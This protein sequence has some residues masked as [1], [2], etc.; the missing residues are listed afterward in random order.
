[1]KKLRHAV[2]YGG[3]RLALAACDRLDPR[4]AFFVADRLADAWFLI[5]RRRRRTAVSN[6][7]A[8]GV[9]TDPRRAFALARA[10]FRHMG[11][12]IVESLKAGDVL[13]DEAGR[14][15]AVEMQIHPGAMEALAAPGRGVIVI[16]GHIGNW[17]IAARMLSFI[18]PVVGVT[19][20]MNN[21]LVERLVRDR[22]PWGRFTLTPKHD[23]NAARFLQTLAGGNI[24][25]LL[26]DQH[27][28]DM[29]HMI[30]FFGRPAA[31]HGSAAL[32][33]LITGAPLCFGYCLR[34]GTMKFRL[35]AL[36]PIVV[37]R[38]GSRK[39]DVETILTRLTA[40]LE[41][42]IRVAPDQYLWAHRRWRD[43]PAKPASS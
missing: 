4:R 19:R 32:L 9:E 23:A 34:S 28:P 18:K 26:A 36:E 27:A 15:S 1:M 24:L 5:D 16:S 33:H 22:K 10:S 29:K 2:E 13:A 43:Q 31:T 42:A 6:I 30:P 17:E 40:E 21:P 25:A 7:I 39:D 11:R 37:K 14:R 3:A 38:T 41:K 35:I 12:V 20:P 8:S